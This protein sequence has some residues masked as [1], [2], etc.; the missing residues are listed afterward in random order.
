M[1]SMSSNLNFFVDLGMIGGGG[2]TAFV[3]VV[4]IG[5]SPPR[6]YQNIFNFQFIEKRYLLT[7]RSIKMSNC[8]AAAA[9]ATSELDMK[10]FSRSRMYESSF[11]K[12]SSSVTMALKVFKTLK[13]K[14]VTF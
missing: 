14:S 9:L 6:C 1:G 2:D 3:F 8:F 7:A 13:M 11:S 10:P 5:A 4:L 12:R